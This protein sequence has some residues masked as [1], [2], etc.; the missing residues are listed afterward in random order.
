[1]GIQGEAPHP[2]RLLSVYHDL[3]RN[4]QISLD[5]PGSP[6]ALAPQQPGDKRP[7]YSYIWRSQELAEL[8]PQV[9]LPSEEPSKP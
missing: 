7:I 9:P 5:L 6:S 8:R 2:P 3:D 4:W 1:M